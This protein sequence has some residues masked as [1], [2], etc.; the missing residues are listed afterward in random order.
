M[1][2]D[3]CIDLN[4]DL[5]ESFGVYSIG[6][7]Q[8][9]LRL[10]TSANVACGRH[11]GD[12]RTMDATVRSSREV[13]VAVGA[14]PGFPDLQG[15]GRRL[16]E[17]SPDDVQLDVLYQIGALHGFCAR[18]GVGLEHVKAHGALYNVALVNPDTAKAIAS[19]VASY[20]SEL[21]FVAPFGSALASAG[22]ESGL[23]IAYEGFADRAYNADGTLVSRRLPGAV[24]SDAV[25]A[26]D[27]AVQMVTEG[28]VDAIT[29]DRITLRVNTVCVH[30]DN[31]D[32]VK[33]LREVRSAFEKNGIRVERMRAVIEAADGN[34]PG[35]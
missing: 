35:R 33:I 6:Q 4:A 29:G 27:R 3:R 34:H 21:L 23:R 1:A 9:V 19:A 28:S 32:A 31:P 5:G 24:I 14:H 25:R 22:R 12:P 7:D 17:M 10:V 26:A 16:I 13:G 2:D 11:A 30:G 18:H 20:N 15:F 8:D